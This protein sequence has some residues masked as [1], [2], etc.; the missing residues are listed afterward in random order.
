MAAPNAGDVRI[1]IPNT[2][3]GV[4]VGATTAPAPTD[5]TTTLDG[6][7]VGV[8][9]I[10]EDGFTE[11]PSTDTQDIVA[12][13]GDIVRR[14]QTSHDVTY[15]FEMI[16][17][18][19]QSLALYY[20]DDNVTATAASPTAGN[21]LA[22]EVKGTQLPRKSVVFEMFDGEVI[23]R[24][25]LPDAQITERSEIQRSHGD[26]ARY[27]VTFTAYPDASGVKAYIW[28]DDGQVAES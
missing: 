2:T 23:E 27:S 24:I 26:A 28:A 22:V 20:G 25:Y 11:S 8:G 6:G 5:A 1:A 17:T 9:Y 4:K 19:A 15:A 18:N 12:W 14:I 16:E 7:F 10:G 3:G 13:G 21:R